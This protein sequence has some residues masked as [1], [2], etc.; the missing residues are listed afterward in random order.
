MIVGIAQL[1]FC[2]GT[3]HV[4]MTLTKKGGVKT[5]SHEVN[6]NCIGLTAKANWGSD[7]SREIG[8][9]QSTQTRFG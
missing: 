1:F 6:I 9:F 7:G 3:I 8:Q 4:P 5:S 2:I